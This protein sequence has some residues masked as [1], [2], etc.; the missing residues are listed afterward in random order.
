[1]QS[2]YSISQISEIEDFARKFREMIYKQSNVQ[3]SR[4][5]VLNAYTKARFQQSWEQFFALNYSPAT[6]EKHPLYDRFKNA[7]PAGTNS[8]VSGRSGR[9]QNLWWSELINSAIESP[10]SAHYV[11]NVVILDLDFFCWER[12]ITG[13]QHTSINTI[14]NCAPL[15]L[16]KVTILNLYKLRYS[17]DMENLINPISGYLKIAL[18]GIC[19]SKTLL[20]LD[21]PHLLPHRL[22]D[23]AL[24]EF[25]GKTKCSFTSLESSKEIARMGANDLF[26]YDININQNTQSKRGKIIY[27]VKF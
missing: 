3:L 24:T 26:N 17:Q 18:K 16:N 27:G 15:T 9:G 20:I 25:E 13:K 10:F 23:W 8:F 19:H 7:K 22:V 21:S 14:R 12:S 11:E 5:D 2:N 4:E 6:E 1:M